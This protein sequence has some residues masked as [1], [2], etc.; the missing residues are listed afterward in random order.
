MIAGFLGGF[1]TGI[2]A[3]VEGCAA[4]G[5]TNPGGA[6][7][8][9]GRQVWVQLVGALFVI[10]WNLA[11]TPLILFFIKYVLRVPLQFDEATLKI[12]DDAIHGEEA[13][14]FDGLRLLHDD[15]GH[16]RHAKR[17]EESDEEK[18]GYSPPAVRVAE[19]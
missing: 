13:Y 15:D 5:L 18:G 9:N 12:G 3:T 1:M 8:G 4:F 6:I 11:V 19:V 16:V 14:V 7:A 2:L 17:D 10:G